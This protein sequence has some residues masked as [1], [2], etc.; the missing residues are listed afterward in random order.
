MVTAA[1]ILAEK[2]FVMNKFDQQGFNAKVA[3]FFQ[4]HEVKDTLLLVPKRF[5]EMEAIGDPTLM[6]EEEL[7][8]YNAEKEKLETQKKAGWIDMT[9]LSI[10]EKKVDNPYDP[11]TFTDYIMAN[12]KGL[13]R[14]MIYIDEPYIKNAAYLLSVVAGFI[15]KKQRGGKWLVSLI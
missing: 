7:E 10:W 15:C 12:N 1:Q 8:A 14:P 3:E 11:F 9:D 13:I 6:S 4:N 2:K 5:V